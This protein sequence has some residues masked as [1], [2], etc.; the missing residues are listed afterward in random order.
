MTD[1]NKIV[2]VEF[3]GKDKSLE[4]QL[5]R[6]DKGAEKVEKRLKDGF[7]GTGLELLEKQVQAGIRPVRDLQIELGKVIQ[8]AK[9]ANKT[10]ASP[11][12]DLAIA[13][14]VIKLKQIQAELRKVRTES[15]ATSKSFQDL[16]SKL[17]S[18]FL[19]FAAL[20][21]GLS[22]F[23]KSAGDAS[24]N[25]TQRL[26]E[27]STIG[28][29]TGRQLRVLR[30]EIRDLSSELQIP[31][32]ELGAGQYQI[33][34][35]GITDVNESFIA[36]EASAKLSKAGLGSV[37]E[38]ADL[39]TSSVNAFGLSANRSAEVLF[40]TILNGKTTA[41]QLASSFGGVAALASQVKVSFEDLNAATA[42]LTI[43]G[44]TASEAQTGI[45]S[46]LV[47]VLKQGSQSVEVA[48]ELGLEFNAAALKAKGFAKFMAEVAEKTGGSEEKLAKLFGR[49]EGLAAALDLGGRAAG[50]YERILQDLENSTGELDKG[51]ERVKN[52]IDGFKTS[53]ANLASAI[54]DTVNQIFEPFAVVLGNIF[55]LLR[56][57][58]PLRDFV[59][60]VGLAATAVTAL[61]AAVSGAVL[62]FGPL[63]VLLGEIGI[64]LGAVAAGFVAV[65]GAAGVFATE[66]GKA[67]DKVED[68]EP[69]F[70]ALSR[71]TD[72]LK[73]GLANL[74][75]IAG[76]LVGAVGRLV[77]KVGEA[78]GRFFNLDEKSKD[79]ETS[80]D[81]LETAGEFLV[82]AFKILI[83]TIDILSSSLAIASI[84]TTQLI[85][86]LDS[87]IN[88]D[89][90]RLGKNLTD[91]WNDISA[92]YQSAADAISQRFQSNT[93]KNLKLLEQLLE[94][95]KNA[96]DES[97]GNGNGGGGEDTLTDNSKTVQQ[98]R[99]AQRQF[100]NI[101]GR[102][103]AELTGYLQGEYAKR[104]KLAETNYQQRVLQLRDLAK[105]GKISSS[106]LTNALSQS[107]QLFIKQMEE[108]N[109]QEQNFLD[110]RQ[111]TI[112][113]LNEQLGKLRSE[114]TQQ[115]PFDN[116]QA[117]LSK[118]LNDIAVEF[119]RKV[120]ELEVQFNF[121]ET[122]E[123]FLKALDIVKET[124][125]TRRRLAIQN[126]NKEKLETL[127]IQKELSNDILVLQAELGGK[128]LEI[129]KAKN[130]KIADDLRQRLL[131]AIRDFGTG[132]DEV[133]QIQSALSK[134]LQ[135]GD[136]EKSDIQIKQQ[137]Q[138]IDNIQAR[139]EL[140]GLTKEGLN[141]QERALRKLIDL[142][143]E[144][145]KLTGL[146]ESKRA[147]I[148][149]KI[150]SAQG[151]LSDSIEQSGTLGRLINGFGNLDF[152]TD[153]IG[154]FFNTFTD[155][156][157]AVNKQFSK[158]KAR[159][160][161]GFKEFI[162]APEG[163]RAVGD[164]VT[165]ISQNLG[166][167]I[168]GIG[169]VFGGAF[170]G[171]IQG[172]LIAGPAGAAVGSL[173]GAFGGG[174]S[175]GFFSGSEGGVATAFALGGPLGFFSLNKFRK[176]QKEQERIARIQRAQAFTQEQ[177]AKAQADDLNSLIAA[178]RAI[179]EFDSGG[180]EAFRIKKQA[181]DQVVELIE[182]RKAFI[183]EAIKQL[184]NQNRILNRTLQ[185]LP[186]DTLQELQVQRLNELDELQVET[187]KALAAFKDSKA[188]QNRI[189]KN[190]ELQRQLIFSQSA[191]A[192]IDTVIAEQNKIAQ[193]RAETAELEA[194]ATGNRFDQIKAQLRA[195]LIRIDS[196][197]AAFKGSEEQK[198]EQIKKTAAERVAAET[199]AQEEIN[200]IL[201]QAN[202]IINEGLVVGQTKAESQ[203]KRLSDLGFSLNSF[204]LVNNA[205]RLPLTTSVSVG[206]GAFTINIEGVNDVQGIIEQIQDPQV[207]Q[208]LA[209][210]LNTAIL[211]NGQ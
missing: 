13:N 203:A 30:T 149:Q 112:Q 9:E 129:A 31:A 184:D 69:H 174:Q 128:E 206:A 45:R 53:F 131:I 168:G 193:I 95:Y 54:G 92:E 179:N 33:L 67:Q 47:A 145:L 133:K 116:I 8:K 207:Q 166:K 198:R 65:G 117:N 143:K 106:E 59:T 103:E 170:A 19:P 6:I 32:A 58:K 201:E 50:A 24:Q 41:S 91:L 49:V 72:L 139:I 211:R 147:E 130:K 113:T 132:S 199:R 2:S 127:R 120:R 177:L 183:S 34:S 110:K 57:N 158:F 1:Q 39:V 210:A 22:L 136:I 162:N 186:G 14:S 164:F 89:F 109:R 161:K 185:I 97:G 51:V 156:L 187:D 141:A 66:F 108:I 29:Q 27:V 61:G 169:E 100:R 194:E 85:K 157:G 118:T 44:R 144:E 98:I 134:T 150:T 111:A 83:S 152:G 121:D 200:G 5:N 28:Q 163:L 175:S 26:R 119:D 43:S 155:G 55:E 154:R 94:D 105:K 10:K 87:L 73:G 64:P 140:E 36:L 68:A 7:K 153:D 21:T 202:D 146:T 102:T 70:D 80:L 135:D 84:I 56:K 35:S 205:D 159:T 11:V 125:V 189:L 77:I 88:F 74:I 42:A 76:S 96:A 208:A 101:V 197:L 122:N 25:F 173:L 180:G 181:R 167:Q 17:S 3:R 142:L 176:Q 124:F 126:A 196:E 151:E 60:G 188:A 4:K 23:F 79:L 204:G 107:N 86:A 90:Q 165:D 114:L 75:D 46:I 16:G 138:L 48:K 137:E 12:N 15:K 18:A 37:S 20:G 104:R 171:G 182:Q 81:E 38:S 160:E 192:I 172:A 82:V 209:D 190:Q 99:N 62:L 63:L 148:L 52:N 195:E 115:D 78:I 191:E 123:E 71:A 40:K 93:K 178:R